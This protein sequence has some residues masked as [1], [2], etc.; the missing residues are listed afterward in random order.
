MH[1]SPPA[2]T[3]DVFHACAR[4]RVGTTQVLCG[5]QQ[6]CRQTATTL[7]GA[8]C[9]SYPRKTGGSEK[10]S[11]RW[12]K[13]RSRKS[14]PLSIDP[15]TVVFEVSADEVTILYVNRARQQWLREQ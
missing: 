6:R 3:F 8:S 15:Y 2:G 5:V 4:E 13:I 1:I 12:G 9:L 11:F 14:Q 7:A 10:K